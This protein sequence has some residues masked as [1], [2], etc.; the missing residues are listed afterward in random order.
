MLTSIQRWLERPVQILIFRKVY[1]CI[2]TPKYQAN[3]GVPAALSLPLSHVP[4][5]AAAFTDGL[6]GHY[7]IDKLIAAV[8]CGV[9]GR[10]W[11]G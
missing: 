11:A 7:E 9:G 4:G 1:V 3:S 5:C 10:L 8:G 6:H 2:R